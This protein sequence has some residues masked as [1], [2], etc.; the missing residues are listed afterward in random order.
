MFFNIL[1]MFVFWFSTFVFYFVFPVFFVLFCVLFLL[2]CIAVSFLFLY[3][4]IQPLPPRGNPTA[5]NKYNIKLNLNVRTRLLQE[6]WRKI[7]QVITF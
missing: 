5:V 6:I 4:C 3:M 7:F 1:V 2:L